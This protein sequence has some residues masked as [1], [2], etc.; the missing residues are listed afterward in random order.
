MFGMNLKQL[1]IST[2]WVNSLSLTLRFLILLGLCTLGLNAHSATRYVTD[3]LTIT[4][5]S[6]ENNT[7]RVI[8]S[9][10]T[11]TSLEIL[12]ENPQSGYSKVK[13]SDG[14]EGYVLTRFLVD[15]VPAKQQLSTVREELEQLRAQPNK[16]EEQLAELQKKFNALNAKQSSLVIENS[17]L[18]QRMNLIRKNASNVV[19]LMD[20]RD[21]VKEQVNELTT[22]IDTLRLKNLELQNHSDKKWFMIG[23]GILAAGLILGLIIP[24]L[25]GG[26]RRT[27]W[28]SG[29]F[30]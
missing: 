7:Y 5:R 26:R 8:K 20:E 19:S 23:A 13:T 15:T 30:S 25:G 3:E 14:I 1:R 4:L 11:G 17:E 6:G 28:S 10:P 24:K 21:K 22:E 16:I 18:K 12:S 2:T 29:G 9:L 27:N